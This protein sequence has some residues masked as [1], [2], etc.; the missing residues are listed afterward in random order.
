[1]AGRNIMKAAPLQKSEQ[2]LKEIPTPPQPVL[3]P[4]PPTIIHPRDQ[5]PQRA[6]P[7]GCESDR[8]FVTIDEF[9]EKVEQIGNDEQKIIDFVTFV[10]K[11]YRV[12]AER[13]FICGDIKIFSDFIFQF[14]TKDVVIPQEVFKRLFSQFPLEFLML[15]D[16]SR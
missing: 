13:N 9:H 15:F 7:I 4:L 2:V 16:L 12:L 10:R 11:N 5:L 1:M 8:F 14:V 3:K 6:P